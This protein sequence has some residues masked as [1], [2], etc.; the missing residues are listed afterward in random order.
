MIAQMVPHQPPMGGVEILNIFLFFNNKYI[1]S[2]I[3]QI[4]LH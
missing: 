2:K 1:L 3:A 4:V